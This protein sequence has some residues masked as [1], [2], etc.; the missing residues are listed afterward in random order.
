MCTAAMWDDRFRAEYE[1][2]EIGRKQFISSKLV[3]TLTSASRVGRYCR[4]HR[5]RWNTRA[6][7]ESFPTGSATWCLFS[8]YFVFWIRKRHEEDSCSKEEKP[9]VQNP[10]IYTSR[11]NV[12]WEPKREICKGQTVL[13]LPVWVKP[14]TCQRRKWIGWLGKSEGCM[15]QTKKLRSPLGFTTKIEDQWLIF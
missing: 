6:K 3:R 4:G 7:R 5:W 2:H 15:V 12:F 9:V 13:K 10:G 1:S 11:G 14:T 8:S